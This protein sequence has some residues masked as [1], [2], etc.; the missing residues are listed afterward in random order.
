MDQLRIYTL[1]DKKT[2]EH[3]FTERWAKDLKIYLAICF[4]I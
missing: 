2:A 3:Y 1:A 4:T